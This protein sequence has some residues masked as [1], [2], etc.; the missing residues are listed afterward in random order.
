MLIN[1][2]K[3]SIE[4]WHICKDREWQL[5]HTQLRPYADRFEMFQKQNIQP[6][7]GLVGLQNFPRV[8]YFMEC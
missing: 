4:V 6:N 8:T 2:K 3:T 7:L 5:C 1:V